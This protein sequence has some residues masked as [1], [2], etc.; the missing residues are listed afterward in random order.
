[1]PPKPTAN[2]S[3][4]RPVPNR[5]TRWAYLGLGWLCVGLGLAGIPLPL[6]PTTPFLLLAAFFFAR[7]STELHDWLVNHP[8]L[9]PPIQDWQ[10][11]G[12]ISRRAKWLATV[13]LTAVI[14]LAWFMRVPEWVIGLQCAIAALVALF[15]WTRPE[16]SRR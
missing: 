12:A 11:E 13:S 10:A 7:G 9:G 15:L 4:G 16:P 6:L 8:R 2:T 1:M 3:I 14:A 5:L